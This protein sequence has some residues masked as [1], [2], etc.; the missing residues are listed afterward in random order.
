MPRECIFVS[1]VSPNNHGDDLC[2]LRGTYKIFNTTEAV[3]LFYLSSWYFLLCESSTCDDTYPTTTTSSQR[4]KRETFKILKKKPLHSGVYRV[5]S[6][7]RQIC[8][9]TSK[10]LFFILRPF[11]IQPMILQKSQEFERLRLLCQTAVV[12]PAEVPRGRA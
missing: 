10:H 1:N 9:S 7:L 3:I 8:Y 6:Q 4:A 11:L 12:P 5:F 2:S